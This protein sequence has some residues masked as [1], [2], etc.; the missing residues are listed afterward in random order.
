L[1][2]LPGFFARR[3]RNLPPGAKVIAAVPSGPAV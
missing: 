1:E 3:T 2:P